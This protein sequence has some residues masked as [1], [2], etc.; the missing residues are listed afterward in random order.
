MRKTSCVLANRS[1][2]RWHHL[3]GTPQFLHEEANST[4]SEIFFGKG[5]SLPLVSEKDILLEL[6]KRLSWLSFYKSEF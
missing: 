4:A 2:S 6:L 3:H 1:M 5:S